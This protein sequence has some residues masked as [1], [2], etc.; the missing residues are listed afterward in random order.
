VSKVNLRPEQQK[1]G[2]TAWGGNQAEFHYHIVGLDL[3][4]KA[5]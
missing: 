4:E 3:E 2:L 1:A 5:E